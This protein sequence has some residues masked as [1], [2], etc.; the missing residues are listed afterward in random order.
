MPLTIQ[1]AGVPY[2]LN[3]VEKK[4]TETLNHLRELK[5]AVTI[6]RIPDGKPKSF[7]DSTFIDSFQL[8]D[9]TKQRPYSLKNRSETDWFKEIKEASPPN[10]YNTDKAKKNDTNPGF[11]TPTPIKGLIEKYHK[12]GAPKGY[13]LSRQGHL[14][15]HSGSAGRPHL[16]G[17]GGHHYISFHPGHREHLRGPPEGD[18]TGQDEEH[19]A[20][21][22]VEEEDESGE[23]EN[24]RE[25]EYQEI[26]K[27]PKEVARRPDPPKQTV[28][29]STVNSG[30][31]SE[32]P[33]RSKA[34]PKKL[35]KLGQ[36]ELKGKDKPAGNSSGGG[37]SK[38]ATRPKAPPKKLKRI[39]KQSDEKA[40]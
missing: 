15:K 13:L 33:T 16:Y 26:G 12:E 35:H 37:E 8:G 36:E 9:P 24:D 11:D 3:G 21:G 19:E 10:G 22:E 34:P 20:G 32:G 25:P 17:E 6:G 23:A 7:N 28:K 40:E 27:E 14:E 31:K 29:K 5:K 39:A 1:Q 4:R 18:E 38:L 30:D 2:L